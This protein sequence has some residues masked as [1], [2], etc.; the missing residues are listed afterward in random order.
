MTRERAKLHLKRAMLHRD[1]LFNAYV[2]YAN[3]KAKTHDEYIKN[4]LI[5]DIRLI[6]ERISNL[7]RIAL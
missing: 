1:Y 5:K 7:Q 3:P 6:N 2:R 4:E